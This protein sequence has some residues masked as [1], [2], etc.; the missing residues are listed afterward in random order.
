MQILFIYKKKTPSVTEFV[1]H[2]LLRSVMLSCL[3]QNAPWLNPDYQPWSIQYL[4]LKCQVL[5]KSQPSWQDSPPQ[6]LSWSTPHPRLC[7]GCQICPLLG[8]W[9][10]A[11]WPVTIK[12]YFIPPTSTWRKQTFL[13]SGLTDFVFWKRPFL[14]VFG[15]TA[16]FVLIQPA[17]TKLFWHWHK[18]AETFSFLKCKVG[19]L[20][21]HE[22]DNNRPCSSRLL[23]KHLKVDQNSVFVCTLLD[24]NL[25]ILGPSRTLCRLP[26]Q[27][28][29]SHIYINTN[30]SFYCQ[31][32]V[33]IFPFCKIS[34][35][36]QMLIC[37]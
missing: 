17:V 25:N 36:S 19:L 24:P 33:G 28:P 34:W 3:G 31:M 8:T 6:T 15:I 4:H 20:K 26:N 21:Y 30:N 22:I 12:I 23:S 29:E 27:T 18:L 14:I 10:S 16:R 32:C 5:F 37:L 1:M 13:H 2:F 35:R 11:C 7:Q 9:H